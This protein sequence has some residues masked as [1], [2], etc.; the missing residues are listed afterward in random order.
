MDPQS[1]PK[2]MTRAR[3]A[4]AES[5]LKTTKIIT[6]AA[7]AKATRSTAT[8]SSTSTKRKARSDDDVEAEDQD[9]DNDELAKPAEPEPVMKATRSRGR[10]KKVAEPEPEPAPAPPARTRGRPKKVVEEPPKHEPTRAAR[11]TRARKAL[12][13]ENPPAPAEVEKKTTTR[14]RATSTAT[15]PGRTTVKKTVKFEEPEKENIAPPAAS[16]SKPATK[17][18]EPAAGL[19]AKPVRKAA[20][21]GRAT[22]ATKSAIQ[23]EEKYDK[24]VPLSPKKITQMALNNRAAD[25]EDELAIDEKTPV[26]PRVRGPAKLPV[27]IAKPDLPPPAKSEDDTTKIPTVMLGSPCRRLPSSPWKDA[28]KSPAK[29]VEGIPSLSLSAGVAPSSQAAQAAQSPFKASLLQSPAKRPQSPI[30]AFNARVST[31]QE[32]L[33]SPFKGSFMSPAKRP[34]SPIKAFASARKQDE[35][36]LDRTPG[37]KPTLLA[38][39]LPQESAGVGEEDV[40]AMEDEFDMHHDELEDDGQQDS[41]SRRFP[42]RLSAVLPRHADPTLASEMLTV[43]ETAEGDEADAVE[44]ARHY[45]VSE[46]EEDITEAGDPMHLDEP[47]AEPAQTERET[48]TPPASPPKYAGAMFSLSGRD[49]HQDHDLDS[50][51]EDELGPNPRQSQADSTSTFDAFPATPCP[52]SSSRMTAHY[53]SGKSV[54]S[55][56]RSTAKRPRMDDKFGFTPLIHQLS[57]WTT[58]SSPVK[59]PESPDV[60]S[61]EDAE[62]GTPAQEQ[63]SPAPAD[64]PTMNAFFE[65]AMSADPH[66]VEP[67]VEAVI[68]AEVEAAL[69][70]EVLEPEFSDAPMS[71]EDLAL[72]KEANEMSLMAP[73]QLE[74]F[75]DHGDPDETLSDASQE[76]GDENDV[77]IDPALLP[78]VPEATVVVP[79]VTPQRMIM[80]DFHT[81]SKVPLKPADDSTPRPKMRKR[82]HSISRLPVQ[83]PTQGLT[84]SATVISYSPTK[85]REQSVPEERET[86]RA[87]SVPPVTPTKSESGWSMA[88]TPARTPRRDL[89]PAL[90]RGAVVF[91]DVHTSEGADASGIFVELLSQMG[92]RCV[93]S[94]PW[95]PSSPP[96]PGGAPASSRIGITHVVY[97]DGGKR[98]LEKVRESAGVVQ[99]VGVS[100]VLE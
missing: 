97:K 42:G 32:P 14:A 52:A 90:L 73:E 41:P 66:A 12:L 8:S 37:P 92:A 58:G 77:P 60:L 48:T 69:T 70:G 5:T 20:A 34:F 68:E 91:V 26:K 44:S 76:Y 33:A 64:S 78:P 39:P 9:Q 57:G 62:V 96:G 87:Q 94:W 16:K 21:T 28:M 25:S 99:C 50:E 11:A 98:T 18:S 53:G 75:V 88:G 56:G 30:K 81:V 38:T 10:P 17:A 67:E 63:D 85:Q 74:D 27:R 55:A 100:W 82:S 95:N 23:A 65:E 2:R 71:A 46:A 45:V 4:K 80:R 6:A 31:Q 49:L 40:G 72:V 79:P 89:N 47:E 29:R 51:S 22:R 59:V 24:P 3:A 84:R 54:K 61:S 83:R 36:V 93:K 43:Q 35:E 15:Q 86:G 7:K 1:P 19:R 13:E